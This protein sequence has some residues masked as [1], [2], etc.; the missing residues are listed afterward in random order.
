MR[1]RP[2]EKCCAPPIGNLPTRAPGSAPIETFDARRLRLAKRYLF[3]ILGGLPSIMVSAVGVGGQR[4]ATGELENLRNQKSPVP[5]GRPGSYP[6]LSPRGASKGFLLV[7]NTHRDGLEKSST[8][9]ASALVSRRPAKRYRAKLL[10]LP[11]LRTATCPALMAR[12][13]RSIVA[14]RP[15][16]REGV[17]GICISDSPPFEFLG[18]GGKRTFEGKTVWKKPGAERGWNKFPREFARPS[19]STVANMR[20]WSADL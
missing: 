18:A 9:K 15:R 1:P 3:E 4:N 5:R 7:S 8:C 12:R 19:Q 16:G 13:G 6:Q 17:A 11:R 14:S 20:A 10:R 2:G